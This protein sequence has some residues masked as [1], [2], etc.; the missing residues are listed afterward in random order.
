[1]RLDF[2]FGELQAFVTVAQTLNFRAAAERLFL[3]QPALSRRIEKLEAALEMRLLERTTRK[4]E[5][6]D[7]G[8][9][10][11]A[12]AAAILEELDLAR[13]SMVERSSRAKQ[14]V[15]VACV[16]SV[17]NHVLPQV[18]YRFAQTHPAVRI[19]IIDESAGM[20]LAAV[21]EGQA[22]IGIGFLG[23][24][25]A[26]V[27]FNPIRSEPY[28][29]AVRR[30][31]PLAAAAAVRWDRLGA[32]RL[33][34]VSL[35]SGNRILIENVLA[36]LPQRPTIHYEANHVAGAL[37]LVAAGLG[38]AVLPSLSLANGAYPMLVGVPMVEPGL[39]R[40]L[41][42]IT[43]SGGRLNLSAQALYD[44]ILREV[45]EPAADTGVN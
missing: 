37:G 35:N 6:S 9:Q 44:L 2:E 27:E 30:D 5:L 10:F 34:G 15:T 43:R 23:A 7:A 8:R 33:I 41:G 42:L 25:N 21:Q 38:V 39:S 20:V 18:L 19:R 32:E 26:E 16:P 4:V 45:A 12:H 3:S 22:D 29:L 24:Q 17:A 13:T 40:T 36:G 14:L 31:H 28:V 11:L 1:M